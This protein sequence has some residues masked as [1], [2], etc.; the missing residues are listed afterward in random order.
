MYLCLI[1]LILIILCYVCKSTF[2]NY[3]DPSTVEINPYVNKLELI[4]HQQKI[5]KIFKE[6][7]DICNENNINYIVIG[8]TLIGTV[9]HNGWIPWDDDIDVAL[10]K[11]DMDKVLS[12]YRNRPDLIDK[13]YVKKGKNKD[14][15]FFKII[16]Y[17]SKKAELFIDIFEL[18]NCDNNKY[19]LNI[20]CKPSTDISNI[21]PY[22]YGTFENLIVPIPNS[23][24]TY[25]KETAFYADETP[26]I[27]KL[28]PI[29]K[30]RPHH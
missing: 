14:W 16:S 23:P 12:I 24:E 8:G 15:S 4:K 17:E 10:F 25:L 19:A 13:Y 18:V 9:R 7:I 3:I 2:V 28:P 21:I 30:R 26:D 1:I 22:D 6:F 11:E 20:N 29:L 5:T 27:N